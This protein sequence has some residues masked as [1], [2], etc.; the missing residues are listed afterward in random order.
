VSIDADAHA[1]WS[2]PYL[3]ACPSLV[4]PSIDAGFRTDK[5]ATPYFAGQLRKSEAGKVL[6]PHFKIAKSGLTGREADRRFASEM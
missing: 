3:A 1:N 4:R 5:R 2:T 6:P